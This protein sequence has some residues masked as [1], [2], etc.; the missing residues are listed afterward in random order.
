MNKVIQWCRSGVK[1]YL[2]VMRNYAVFRGR[3]RRREYW[4]FALCNGIG[5]YSMVG[6]SALSGL[7]IYKT[8]GVFDTVWLWA[9]ILPGIAVTVRRLHDTGRSGWWFFRFVLFHFLAMVLAVVIAIAILEAT[10]AGPETGIFLG[11][12]IFFLIA[13]AFQ[14]WLLLLLTD[15]SHPGENKYGPNPKGIPEVG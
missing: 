2:K 15:D 13:I 14:I 8:M 7:Y 9:H 6:I 10:S 5:G 3:A 1:Y 12:G 4:F 11:F